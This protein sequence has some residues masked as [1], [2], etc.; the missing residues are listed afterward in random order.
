MILALKQTALVLS[1]SR[2]KRF[3]QQPCANLRREDASVR[4]VEAVIVY[5]GEPIQRSKVMRRWATLLVA[6]LLCMQSHAERLTPAPAEVLSWQEGMQAPKADIDVVRWLEGKWEG[7]LNNGKQEWTALPPLSGD[8]PGLGRGWGPD[9]SIW[10]YEISLFT[11]VDDSVEFRVKHFSQQLSGWEG[12]DEYVRHRLIAVT[13]EAVFFD[14]IT[15]AKNGPDAHTVRLRLSDGER[16][17]QIITVHQR[18][19]ALR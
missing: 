18:R 3:H 12:K 13:D 19:A 16:K 15:F 14:G 4:R 10:F 8:M 17:G 7:A 1:R 2:G 6:L 11:E 5:T 9:E